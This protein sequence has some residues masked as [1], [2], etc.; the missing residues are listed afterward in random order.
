M[1]NGSIPDIIVGRLP[2]YLQALQRMHQE[3][4]HTTSSK[5]LGDRLG[6]TA[7]QIRKDLSQF[8]EF[9]KQGTGYS[10]PFLIGQL[11]TILKVDRMW[12]ILLVGAGSLGHAIANYNGFANRGFRIALI[13]DNDPNKIG[14][15]IANFVVQDASQVK[16]LLFGSGIKIAMLTVPASNAQAVAEELTN[17]GIKAILNYAPVPLSLPKGIHVEYIDPLIQLQH[18]TYYID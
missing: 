12:D 14:T 15:K 6:Y 18:M 3:G 16:A 13:V 10:I 4:R 11:Q 17:A 9:G 2:R 8:G 1:I 7:A 5:E